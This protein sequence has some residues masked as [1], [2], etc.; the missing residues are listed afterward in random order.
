VRS[1]AIAESPSLD[2]EREA[3]LSLQRQYTVE[4]VWAGLSAVHKPS[5]QVQPIVELYVFVLYVLSGVVL[6]A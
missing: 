3:D 4:C 5:G 1:R 6:F 2:G